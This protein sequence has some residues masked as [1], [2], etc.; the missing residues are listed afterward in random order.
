MVKQPWLNRGFLPRFKVSFALHGRS[1][2]LPVKILSHFCQVYMKQT[3]KYPVSIHAYIMFSQRIIVSKP[4]SKA[5]DYLNT[6]LG[7]KRRRTH[8]ESQVVKTILHRVRKKR[9]PIVF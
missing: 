1:G 8:A 3:D 6:K 7:T 2:L 9:E 4:N 5:S